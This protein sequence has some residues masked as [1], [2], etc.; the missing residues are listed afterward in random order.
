M[1]N[2]KLCTLGYFRK[3]IRDNG[4]ESKVLIDTFSE[5]DNRKW[6]ISIYRDCSIICTCL[7]PLIDEQI[8]YEFIFS[9]NQ[10]KIKPVIY[11]IKTDSL[12]VIID[13]LKEINKV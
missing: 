9:D 3:R 5:K 6:M 1:A 12:N 10:Q 8:K 2:N 11:T 13:F 4:I 7:K